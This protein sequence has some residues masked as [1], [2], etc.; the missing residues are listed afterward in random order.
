MLA[1]G[2]KGGV[3]RGRLYSAVGALKEKHIAFLHIDTVRF[4]QRSNS[5]RLFFTLTLE[6]AFQPFSSFCCETSNSPFRWVSFLN[7]DPLLHLSKCVLS[8]CMFLIV[9]LG[10]KAPLIN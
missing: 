2:F 7:F 9:G 8:L 10:D 3:R 1:L 4:N 5:N 6:G